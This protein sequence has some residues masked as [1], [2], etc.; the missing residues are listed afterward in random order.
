MVTR[1]CYISAMQCTFTYYTTTLPHYFIPTLLPHGHYF[2]SRLP[3]LTLLPYYSTTPIPYYLTTRLPL[4]TTPIPY[5]PTTPISYY[6]TTSLPDYPNT[7][8]TT[9]LPDYPNTSLRDY[10]N[11]D[12]TNTLLPQYLTT[13]LLHC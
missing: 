6:L 1:K 8:I 10:P 5:Y 3:Q 12:Y 2:S 4:I 9:S 11:T 13:R 7:L